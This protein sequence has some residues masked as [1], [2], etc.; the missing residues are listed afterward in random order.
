M[1]FKYKDT[2]ATNLQ[3]YNSLSLLPHPTAT[4]STS[5]IINLVDTDDEEFYRDLE[6]QRAIL[7][8]NDSSTT[9][10][11]I[12]LVGIDDDEFHLDIETQRTILNWNDSSDVF[13]TLIVHIHTQ[14]DIKPKVENLDHE[15]NI[16]SSS[17][18]GREHNQ[19]DPSS[20]DQ[21]CGFSFIHVGSSTKPKVNT[22]PRRMIADEGYIDAPVPDVP[23]EA[24]DN[25]AANAGRPPGP[26][27]TCLYSQ[28]DFDED[29]SQRE[30]ERELELELEKEFEHNTESSIGRYELETLMEEPEASMGDYNRKRKGRLHPPTLK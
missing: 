11:I 10:A 3:F 5:V 19:A 21:G 8:S 1:A 16:P 2:K 25:C 13:L 4:M 17:C 18:H 20:R 14:Q 30:I 23:A 28:V 27:M 15:Y 29:E 6:T 12:D 7:N 9:P 26:K 22:R 24:N